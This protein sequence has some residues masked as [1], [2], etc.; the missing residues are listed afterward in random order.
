MKNNIEKVYG[1]LPKKKLGLKK[2]KVDLSIVEDIQNAYDN[3]RNSYDEASYLA[4]EWGDEIIEAYEDFRM[5]YNLDNYIVNG[6]TRYLEERGEN[7]QGLVG[8]FEN[9][10]NDLGI[11]P[12]ELIQGYDE[13]IFMIENYKNLNKDAE[14]KNREVTS[15][16]GMPNFLT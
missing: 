7:M 2:H 5:K 13:I 4:Y 3:F 15:Y 9:K 1:K 10:A 8:E 12:A 16:T 6:N 11:D 14:D